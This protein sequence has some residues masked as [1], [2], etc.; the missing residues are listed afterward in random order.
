[1]RHGPAVEMG[2]LDRTDRL[3]SLFVGLGEELRDRPVVQEHV[4]V[5]PDDEQSTG[6]GVHQGAQLGGLHPGLARRRPQR[7][8]QMSTFGERGRHQQREQR[9]DEHVTLHDQCPGA[10]LADV[11]ERAAGVE[12]DQCEGAQRDERAVHARDRDRHAKAAPEQQTQRHEGDRQ[13]DAGM[14]DQPLD[15]H[16][17][18][19][20]RGD[21]DPVRPPVY[22]PPGPCREGGGGHD[23]DRGQITH[24]PRD[25]RLDARR[26]AGAQQPEHA[27][28][29]AGARREDGADQ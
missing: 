14:K 7:A 25:G 9:D 8:R 27:D 16:G 2:E 29:G 21:F 6:Q 1:M 26:H 17:E 10:R 11:A 19:H 5:A 4:P 18:R 24:D 23:D 22:S 28:E 20:E 13:G 12:V 15:H 3:S